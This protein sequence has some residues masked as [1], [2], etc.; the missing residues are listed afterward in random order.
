MRSMSIHVG[1]DHVDPNA[2]AGWRGDLRNCENDAREMARL[3]DMQGIVERSVLLTRDATRAHLVAAF[4]RAAATL[5]YND[6]LLVTFSG[7]GGWLEDVPMPE[8]ASD[9]GTG[10]EIDGRDEAWCLYDTFLLDDEIRNQ[11]SKLMSGVRVCVVSDSCYSGT[12]TRHGDLDY[13]MSRPPMGRRPDERNIGGMRRIA[14][15]LANALYRR[16]FASVYRPRKLA[17]A[18]SCN[19]G[20]GAHIVLLAACQDDQGASEGERHGLFTERLLTTWD[21]GNYSGSHRGFLEQIR[22]NMPKSQQPQLYLSGEISD[23]FVNSRP[24]TLED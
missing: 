5:H 15:Q 6:Y 21:G 19:K 13:L 20:T 12:V 4:D 9:G 3:A 14:Y 7:H 22:S 2:Y 24:F 10:D 16:G 8:Q 11:L 23:R 1:L 17:A 18:A